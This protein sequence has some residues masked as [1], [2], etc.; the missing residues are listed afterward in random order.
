LGFIYLWM[1]G[2]C[3]DASETYAAGGFGLR[4]T[5][6]ISSRSSLGFAQCCSGF[7]P[8]TLSVSSKVVSELPKKLVDLAVA[9]VA[10]RAEAMVRSFIVTV[11]ALPFVCRRR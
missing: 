1:E 9:V 11:F 6:L 5:L 10:R 2:L 8:G 4:S 3:W 7:S